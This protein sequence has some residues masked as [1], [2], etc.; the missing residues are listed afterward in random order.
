M[1]AWQEASTRYTPAARQ[2]GVSG[3][4][5]LAVVPR[6][7]APGSNT[8]ADVSRPK[9]DGWAEQ[10]STAVAAAAGLA[11]PIDPTARHA[12]AM[13]A[14]TTLLEQCMV[15]LVDAGHVAQQQR[16]ARSLAIFEHDFSRIA[17]LVKCLVEGAYLDTACRLS[18]LSYSGVRAWLK[19]YDEGDPR[20]QYVGSLIRAAEGIAEH[21]AV[22]LVRT[23]G[24]DARFWAAPATWLER[25]FPAK[26]GRRP[27]DN[28]V[29]RVVVQIGVKDSDVQINVGGSAAAPSSS[30]GALSD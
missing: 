5:A 16:D 11:V 2:E 3:P 29:P 24:H 14:Y 23:A 9:T 10:Q 8:P 28:D 18:D 7:A 1:A 21:E 6:P 17:N 30:R 4:P 25:K 20:H 12:C 27:E 26:Y 19:S 13:A 22:I 15:R